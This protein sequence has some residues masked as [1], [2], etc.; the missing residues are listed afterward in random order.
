MKTGTSWMK[1]G[2]AL[3]VGTIC[4]VFAGPSIAQVE[5]TQSTKAG[6][7][8]KEVTGERG[9]VVLVEGNDLVVKMEDGSVRHIANVPESAK[10]TADRKQPGSHD[11]KAG[12]E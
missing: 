12:I 8:S 5:T 10:I 6:P 11:L 2:L 4:C 7:A 1:T 3:A 9:E